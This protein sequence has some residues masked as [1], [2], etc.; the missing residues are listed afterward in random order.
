MNYEKIYTQLIDRAQ[1]ENRQKGCG[2]YF[3]SHH[4][5]PKCLTGSNDKTNLVLLTAREHYVAHKLLCEIYIDNV[6]LHYAMWAMINGVTKRTGYRVTSWDYNRIK[7]NHCVSVQETHTNKIVSDETRNK[8]SIFRLNNERI[9]CQYC[10]VISDTGNINR[11]HNDN[12]K[13]NPNNVLNIHTQHTCEY[14]DI[15]TTKT[16]IIRWHNEKCKFK[17][18]K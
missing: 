6:K 10:N 12:C 18:K 16:N 3:E 11:W 17:T 5:I 14:C 8:Q 1:S 13:D 15:R 9:M 7:Q 2:V 4:I